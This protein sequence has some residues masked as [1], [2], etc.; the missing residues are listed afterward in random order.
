MLNNHP[1]HNYFVISDN[2]LGFL[3]FQNSKVLVI[4][5]ILRFRAYKILPLMRSF[6]ARLKTTTYLEYGNGGF[7]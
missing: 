1:G 3:F 6:Y 2:L 5:R 4:S 7:H